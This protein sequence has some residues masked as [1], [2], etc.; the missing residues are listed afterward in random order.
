MTFLNRGLI[1]ENTQTWFDWIKHVARVS[2][3]FLIDRIGYDAVL[4]LRFLRTLRVLLVFMVMIAVGILMPI[5]VA[6][7]RFTG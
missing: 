1:H 2:D 4:F 6:A 7:T 5:N 3:D